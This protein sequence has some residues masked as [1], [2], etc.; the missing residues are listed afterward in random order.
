MRPPQNNYT[1]TRNSVNVLDADS[2]ISRDINGF[3]LH[4]G[5]G[6]VLVHHHSHD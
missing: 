6:T 5:T 2:E 3:T 1:R 4:S